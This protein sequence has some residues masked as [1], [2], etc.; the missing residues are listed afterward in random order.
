MVPSNIEYQR[1][2]V[3]TLD[4]QVSRLAYELPLT[5][6]LKAWALALCKWGSELEVAPLIL[7]NLL[8]S[9]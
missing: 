1:L 2:K 9:G 8:L 7:F 3:L 5:E 4:I 6:N